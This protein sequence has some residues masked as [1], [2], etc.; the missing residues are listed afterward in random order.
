MSLLHTVAVYVY[1][2]V[3]L[4]GLWGTPSARHNCSVDIHCRCAGGVAPGGA[5]AAHV[6]VAAVVDPAVWGAGIVVGILLRGPSTYAT[7]R[8]I[9]LVG[10]ENYL[11]GVAFMPALSL[12]GERLAAVAGWIP[13]PPL[14][15]ATV[16]AGSEGVGGPA[17]IALL[18]W[19]ARPVVAV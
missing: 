9:R 17:G 19:R 2:T 4:R 8:A 6:P 18:R 13:E 10:S 7:F 16:V 3:L 1:I 14:S 11:M 5:A 15:G 12:A